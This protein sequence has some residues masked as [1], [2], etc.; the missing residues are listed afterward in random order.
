ML[1]N[2]IL[3]LL[4][5]TSTGF[6]GGYSWASSI[7]AYNRD[8]FSIDASIRQSCEFQI[9]NMF[10]QTLAWVKEEIR[11]SMTNRVG[12][13]SSYTLITTLIAG[14][15]TAL[16]STTNSGD[17]FP[18][19]A[20]GFVETV[21]MLTL[22]SSL[23][24]LAIAV[25]IGVQES[26]S[27]YRKWNEIAMSG[28]DGK[29]EDY[30]G[31]VR[32]HFKNSTEL[33]TRQFEKEPREVVFRPPLFSRWA[34][35]LAH[36][37]CFTGLA[38][39]V[40]SSA[41]HGI[42]K[43]GIVEAWEGTCSL[44]DR[45]KSE[46]K[47]YCDDKQHLLR[48]MQVNTANGIKN[49]IDALGYICL[50][51]IYGPHGDAFIFWVM[52]VMFVVM[53]MQIMSNISEDVTE[54]MG[55][56]LGR[57]SMPVKNTVVGAT[58]ACPMCLLVAASTD[59]NVIDC[60]FIPLGFLFHFALAAFFLLVREYEDP[61]R[62]HIKTQG[63]AAPACA[64]TYALDVEAPL[65]TSPAG[66]GTEAASGVEA[67]EHA[68]ADGRCST[69]R[70]C[71]GSSIIVMLWLFVML[72]ACFDPDLGNSKYKNGLGNS[73]APLS[74]A[75]VR[76]WIQDLTEARL[77]PKRL[78]AS[79][80]GQFV[81]PHAIAC[82]RTEQFG[83]AAYVADR[84]QVFQLSEL[85]TGSISTKLHQ[86]ASVPDGAILDLTFICNSSQ[87]GPGIKSRCSPLLLVSAG[88][89]GESTLFDCATGLFEPLLQQGNG[90]PQPTRLTL[91]KENTLFLAHG[92]SVLQY[93]RLLMDDQLKSRLG[94]AANSNWA[95]APSSVV[96]DIQWASRKCSNV[97][98]L[99]ISG[100]MLWLTAGGD[101]PGCR[102]R[103]IAWSLIKRKQH[104]EWTTSGP[105][106][107]RGAAFCTPANESGI[108]FI[109][110]VAGQSGLT[111]GSKLW[112]TN[113]PEVTEATLE[114]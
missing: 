57:W 42:D 64:S 56:K 45:L 25:A 37:P 107:V 93:R 15:A 18:E 34:H 62:Q 75:R 1:S 86:C 10:M 111:S 27:T 58:A 114:M 23:F 9:D 103:L 72:W 77:E 51:Q 97:Q 79:W 83:T 40:D 53:N 84:F 12:E 92:H 50:A 2:I 101:N 7:Y 71:F 14:I 5:A 68:R 80:P 28:F 11:D 89:S 95:W 3:T 98:G 87:A 73:I 20:P 22:G 59:H 113:V 38:A 33:L 43:A 47:Q 61:R 41:E 85:S 32:S 52:Q 39:M 31:F 99:D 91:R 13:L 106:F 17:N 65:V 109:T 69:F 108:Y 90:F 35:K 100:S 54:I 112:H 26:I 19:A 76:A 4:G 44:M 46:W 102:P 110:S 104:G 6:G 49:L 78:N 88:A 24:H 36:K 29:L 82:R 70:K 66:P 67:D 30:R 74:T 94:G 63:A 105:D 81:S 96:V 21:Y 60:V 8:A 16:L 48:R 55:Y